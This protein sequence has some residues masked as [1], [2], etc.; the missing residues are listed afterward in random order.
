MAG[1]ETDVCVLQSV[2]GLIEAGQQIFLLED[3]L[4]SSEPNI[5]PAIRR[6]ESAGLKPLGFVAL[7]GLIA[8]LDAPTRGTI[9]IDGVDMTNVPPAKPGDPVPRPQVSVSGL[10]LS[11]LLGLPVAVL[12]LIV[13][14]WARPLKKEVAHR[15]PKPL[16]DTTAYRWSRLIQHH[17]WPAAL[18]V[19]VRADHQGDSQ[20][21]H[22]Q[23]VLVR[24]HQR[25]L[26]IV[27][28]RFIHAADEL[29]AALQD[30]HERKAWMPVGRAQ[31]G[32][33]VRR[34]DGDELRLA[35]PLD[36]LARQQPR[37]LA[38]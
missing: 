12:V 31:G 3:A 26:R 17:P 19:F 7:L 36:E 2:L 13:G 28:P 11:F 10:P 9:A 4:F 14:V 33:E 37:R 16:R 30:A 34:T 23:A 32:V 38:P 1:A 15:P 35:A 29:G 8:G 21:G 5:G 25:P 24:Q 27:H 20:R 6:M 22:A 18:G